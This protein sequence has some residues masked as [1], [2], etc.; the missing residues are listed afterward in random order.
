MGDGT[1][2][3]TKLLYHVRNHLSQKFKMLGEGTTMNIMLNTLP[4]VG[5]QIVR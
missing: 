1:S 5:E 2:Q 4:H 3:K